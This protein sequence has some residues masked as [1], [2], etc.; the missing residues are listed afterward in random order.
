M[1]WIT[2]ITNQVKLNEG[3]TKRGIAATATGCIALYMIFKG[4]PVDFDSLMN[5]V[6]NKVGFWL[7][8]GL[9]VMGFLGI[10]VPDEKPKPPA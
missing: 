7:G 9:N 6:S 8:I 4:Q 1:S 5:I 3:S 10:F 2:T